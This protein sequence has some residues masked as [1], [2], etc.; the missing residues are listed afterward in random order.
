M[1]S[2]YLF[3]DPY[4]IWFY[5]ITGSALTDFFIGTFVLALI[6]IIIGEFTISLTFLAVKRRIDQTTDEVIKFQNLS[7]DALAAGDKQVYSAANKLANDAF[8][9]SFFMQIALSAAFLWPIC[10]A[11]AWMQYRF[12]EV[13]FPLP[14]IGYSLNYIGVFIIIYAVTYLLFKRVKYKLPFFRRIKVILDSYPSRFQDMKSFA[15][16]GKFKPE[17]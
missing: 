5:R 6:V 1:P 13:E 11:L 2:F 16:L 9:K 10:F 15:D 7:V 8:G 4:L 14:V 12:L 3:L 17:S